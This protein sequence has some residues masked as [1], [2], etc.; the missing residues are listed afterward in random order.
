VEERELR[1]EVREKLSS[2][3]VYTICKDI[4]DLCMWGNRMEKYLVVPEIK[5]R[6]AALDRR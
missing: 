5:K 1:R 3:H 4:S 2:P 6:I